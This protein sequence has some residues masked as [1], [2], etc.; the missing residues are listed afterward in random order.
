MPRKQKILLGLLVVLALA[1]V[2][3]LTSPYEQETVERLTYARATRVAPPKSAGGA[4]DVV[5]L[6]LL[7]VPPR[8]KVD[9]QRDLF[10]PPPAAAASS[11]PAT[12]PQAPVPPPPPKT[13]RQKIQE[14]FQGFK[15]FGSYR[16]GKDVYLFL[17]RGKQVLI[18]TRGDR[19]DGKYEI[20]DLNEKSIT[21][22]AK[23][24]SQPLQ[25]DFE[26]L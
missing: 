19:I 10:R 7:Q 2:Y 17:E 22:T 23:G 14:H 12:K 25:I 5:R 24:L 18:V 13:E 8:S 20:T 3:R 1:L 11:T 9:V 4:A 26:E 16:H 15:T 21:I 6:N